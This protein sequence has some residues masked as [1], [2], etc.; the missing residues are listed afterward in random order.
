[1]GSDLLLAAVY[2]GDASSLIWL[3]LILIG[4]GC[5][6]GAAYLAYLRNILGAALLLVVA[7]IAFFLA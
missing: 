5:L 6:L 3:V 7:I 2:R 4:V 1:M